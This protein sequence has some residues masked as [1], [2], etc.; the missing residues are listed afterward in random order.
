[1]TVITKIND[2]KYEN[3]TNVQTNF[4]QTHIN[5]CYAAILNRKLLKFSM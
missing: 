2:H 1:M 5:L 3:G 4:K